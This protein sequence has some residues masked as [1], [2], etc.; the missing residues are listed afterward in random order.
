M[1]SLRR[2]SAAMFERYLQLQQ[3]TDPPTNAIHHL[4]K[5]LGES[6]CP[7]DSATMRKTRRPS[8]ITLT[9]P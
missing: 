8:N 6:S 2:P 1:G 5:A 4:R 3:P 9:R 7:D